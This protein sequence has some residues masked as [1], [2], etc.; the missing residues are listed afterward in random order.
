M[1]AMKIIIDEEGNIIPRAAEA[2]VAVIPM[3]SAET[4]REGKDMSQARIVALSFT[5]PDCGA[6]RVV[7]TGAQ[8]SHEC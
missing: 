2:F 4:L 5:C 7:H 3:S 6:A 1:W 8:Y